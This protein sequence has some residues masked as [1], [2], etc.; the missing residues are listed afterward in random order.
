MC[1]SA[2]G[3]WS[4]CTFLTVRWKLYD[5]VFQ[6]ALRHFAAHLNRQAATLGENTGDTAVHNVLLNGNSNEES[7]IPSHIPWAIVTKKWNRTVEGMWYFGNVQTKG[8][9]ELFENYLQNVPGI[10][11]GLMKD[12]PSFLWV[13]M[14][15][16]LRWCCS[17]P[18]SEEIVD[19]RWQSLA[20]VA[21]DLDRCLH[22]LF[23]CN[24]L[25][26][27]VMMSQHKTMQERNTL[28]HWSLTTI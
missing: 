12:Y 6:L 11:I 2:A 9:I 22:T 18:L 3:V 23:L 13:K 15:A 14:R 26:C 21:S 7:F 28:C 27:D 17:E 5:A 25:W 10:R 16:N 24:C 1:G 8:S 20:E 4:N 19:G